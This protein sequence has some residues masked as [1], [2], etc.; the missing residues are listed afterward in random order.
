[1]NYPVYVIDIM[2]EVVA[3]TGAKLGIV[4]NFQPGRSL[5]IV[6]SLSNDDNSVN[7]K[8]GKYP[9]FAL[10]V[11]FKE[12]FTRSEFYADVTFD[13]IVIATLAEQNTTVLER[14]VIGQNFK[15]ILYPIY[16]EFLNQLAVHPNISESDPD[17]ISHYKMDNP[18]VQESP[19]TNDFID[20]IE[21]TGLSFTLIQ[22]KTC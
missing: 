11:P 6:K 17:T 9:L 12:D 7:Y 14:Y 5:Q 13:K 18:G 2:Q 16:I 8:G 15:T 21:I 20:C 3:A 1:M 19:E 4:I 22:T 10:F